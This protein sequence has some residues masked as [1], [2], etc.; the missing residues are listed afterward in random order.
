MDRNQRARAEHMTGQAR[1]LRQQFAQ[2]FAAG[3]VH[4]KDR[5]GRNIALNDLVV[6]NPPQPL[7]F[8][9]VGLDAALDPN[10]P[11]GV[12][13]VVLNIDVPILWQSGHAAPELIVV[14]KVKEQGHT[15]IN[16]TRPA[17]GPDAPVEQP[18]E[19]Q[20]PTAVMKPEDDPTGGGGDQIQ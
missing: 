14:G 11:P 20:L 18:V 4:V 3:Q 1:A 9:V 5:F 6:Y 2:A 7:V 16:A 8:Q 13:R 12:I 10:V 17:D 19:E 15:E